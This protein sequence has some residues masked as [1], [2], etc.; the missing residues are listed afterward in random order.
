MT[1]APTKDF[2]YLQSKLEAR[3]AGWRSKCLSWVR[4]RTLITLVT[5]TIP[6]YARST[7][8]IPNKV[9]NNL[10]SLTRRF[11]WKPKNHEGNFLAWRSW[12]KLC[13]PKKQGGL[14]FKKAK[15]VNNALLAK[16]AWMIASKR[17]SLCM[18]ILR[19]KYKISKNWLYADSSKCVSPIWK[20]IEQAKN[21]VVKG[22]C[23]IIGDGTTINDW[24][25][26]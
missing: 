18:S 23:Y 20:A 15:E 24:Q 19:A 8:N 10:D 17:D 1:R 6:N 25:D 16:L 14:G 26:P 2:T 12:D 7:F 22:A 5:Q 9:C 3:L 13:F 21:V 4:R 11:W